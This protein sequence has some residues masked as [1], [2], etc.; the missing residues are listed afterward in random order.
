MARR[1]ECQ[2]ITNRIFHECRLDLLS[3][4]VKACLCHLTSGLPVLCAKC[5]PN[6]LS[7]ELRPI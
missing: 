1:S 3:T 2:A 7:S 4:S 6:S 5:V